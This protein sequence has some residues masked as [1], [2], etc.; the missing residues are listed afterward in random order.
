MT[1]RDTSHAS[2]TASSVHYLSGSKQTIP[3]HQKCAARKPT[4]RPAKNGNGGNALLT[5]QVQRESVVRLDRIAQPSKQTKLATIATS[6]SVQI[7]AIR[8]PTAAS[9]ATTPR[10]QRRR[11]TKSPAVGLLVSAPRGRGARSPG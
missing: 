11:A 8:T 7:V 9:R 6:Q 5:V 3:P 4:S 10:M 1:G 2:G